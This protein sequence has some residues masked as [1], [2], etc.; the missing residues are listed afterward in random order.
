M[1]EW[2]KHTLLFCISLSICYCIL[3]FGDWFLKI[4]LNQSLKKDVAYIEAKKIEKDR[5][6]FEDLPQ[7]SQAL[8]DGF[9]PVLYPDIIENIP[10]R[11]PLIAGLPF[12]DTYYCNEGYGLVKYKSDRF[13][14]RNKD[15]LWD[16]D[17]TRIFIGD[18]FIHGACVS[19]EDTLPVQ[20]SLKLNANVLNLGMAS[21]GPSHYLTYASLFIPLIQPKFVYLNFYPN[22]NNQRGISLIEEKYVLQKTSIFSADKIAFSN[23]RRIT[24]EGRKAIKYL[25]QEQ[26][27]TLSGVS[28]NIQNFVNTFSNHSSLP[29]LTELVTQKVSGFE[30][31]KR[32]ILGVKELCDQ[33]ECE[34]KVSFIPN[35][36]FFR[37]DTRADGYGDQI[38]LLTKRLEIPFVDGREFLDRSKGSLDFAPKGPH[39]SSLGYKKMAAKIAEKE[40]A[41]N[42]VN[43]KN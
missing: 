27:Q 40:K 17:P 39:L 34:L 43:I 4:T 33:H 25:Q 13:G 19:N 23:P 22:D 9:I 15:W 18:S 10:L 24:E 12:A 30:D 28:N 1:I 26:H 21:N 6:L 16:E 2:I 3:M 32:V 37:P 14:F 11:Y 41:L 20:L 8:S 36:Y 7:R 42:D 29:F 38:S 35:N 31:T 5:R